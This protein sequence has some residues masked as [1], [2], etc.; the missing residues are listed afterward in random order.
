VVSGFLTWIEQS[1]LGHVV[2]DSGPWTYP[3]VNLVHIL[4]IATLFGSIVVLDLALLG[5][6]RKQSAPSASAMAHTVPPVAA[7]GFLT[8]L[9]SGVGLLA[10]N[11]SEYIGNPFLLIEFPAIALGV[12][13]AFL[14]TRSSAWRGLRGGAVSP[15][16]SHRLRLMA[17]TSLACWTVAIAA[18]RMIGYW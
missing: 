8:A 5:V 16:D 1:A 13:N 3:V 6:G 14:V 11:G 4:G 2:R 10:S 17:A 15:A 12:V 9:V 7:A 18:G